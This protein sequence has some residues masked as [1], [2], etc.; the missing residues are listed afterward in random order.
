MFTLCEVVILT[1]FPSGSTISLSLA[2][3]SLSS[4]I[5]CWCWFIAENNLFLVWGRIRPHSKRSEWLGL[6]ES[7]SMANFQNFFL[8]TISLFESLVNME[9][10]NNRCLKG[11]SEKGCSWNG[12]FGESV[13]GGLDFQS[14]WIRT[15]LRRCYLLVSEL[16][17]LLAF[18]AG[19]F[20]ITL[21]RRHSGPCCILGCW[22]YCVV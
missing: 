3:S 9:K 13:F 12:L 8:E 4:S 5:S 21:P 1:T 2:I 16:L 7:I 10:T 18:P 14:F 20:R 6:Q 11:T 17:I 15:V 19:L 22:G